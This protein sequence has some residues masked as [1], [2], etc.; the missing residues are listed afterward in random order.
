MFLDKHTDKSQWE[1]VSGCTLKEDENRK[2]FLKIIPTG[3]ISSGGIR[4]PLLRLRMMYDGEPYIIYYFGFAN[5]GSPKNKKKATGGGQKQNLGAQS[6]RAER[7]GDRSERY[8]KKTLPLEF[9]ISAS[10]TVD[11]IFNH[12]LGEPLQ[13]SHG[14]K[15]TRDD[16]ASYPLEDQPPTKRAR[17]LDQQPHNDNLP[18]PE[19]NIPSSDDIKER[20][21]QAEDPWYN[22]DREEVTVDSLMRPLSTDEIGEMLQQLDEHQETSVNNSLNDQNDQED[23][24]ESD[25]SI[26]KYLNSL[27]SRITDS[28]LIDMNVD[29]Q[30]NNQSL[31][32]ELEEGKEDKERAEPAS[33]PRK[34]DTRVLSSSN[35]TTS[36]LMNE[37]ANNGNSP[38]APNATHLIG[39]QSTHCSSTEVPPQFN[40]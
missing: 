11:E 21:Q 31:F 35:S 17:T 9:H 4:L 39:H 32:D 33:K 12:L 37:I 19:T 5:G 16:D 30:D 29:E 2:N 18:S 23:T 20:I 34:M 24:T 38:V 8:L 27:T 6:S 10:T 1:E 3:P 26:E 22:N 40:C 28:V 7:S 36:C 15:T 25:G 13:R 14:V